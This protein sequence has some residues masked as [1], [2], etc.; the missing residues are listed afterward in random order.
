MKNKLTFA[1]LFAGLFLSKQVYSAGECLGYAGSIVDFISF[2]AGSSCPIITSKTV[3]GVE[4]ELIRHSGPLNNDPSGPT[5][6]ICSVFSDG[7][8]TLGGPWKYTGNPFGGETGNPD[9]LPPLTPVRPIDWQEPTLNN[10][11]EAVNSNLVKLSES[12]KTLS[13]S[14][15]NTITDSAANQ[16][17]IAARVDKVNT[18]VQAAMSFNTNQTAQ[19]IQTLQSSLNSAQASIKDNDDDNFQTLYDQAERHN[20]TAVQGVNDIRQQANQ[21]Q[22]LSWQVD[23][24]MGTVLTMNNVMQEQMQQVFDGQQNSLNAQ[25]QYYSMLQAPIISMQQTLENLPTGGSGGLSPEDSENLEAVAE[26]VEDTVDAVEDVED[27]ISGMRSSLSDDLYWTTG[28]LGEK[29][30]AINSTLSNGSGGGSD[31]DTETNQ[32]LDGIGQGIQEISDALKAGSGQNTGPTLCT[33]DDCYKGKSWVTP[34][35]P[36]GITS[37]YEDHK[38]KFQDSTIHEYMKGFVPQLSGA[39][40]NSWEF[41]IN[42]DGMAN[43]G[44]HTVE[45]P[46]YVI[47]FVRLIILISAGFLCRRLIF[48]G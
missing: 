44:C 41:C 19:Q 47:S 3:S 14:L 24:V 38:A 40:P 26:G 27:A 28:Q 43:L 21:I 15:N 30:D 11:G 25:D 8:Q 13:A 37:I 20:A 23:G 17:N 36:E 35:Y 33:G 46:P 31:D 1:L 2:P 39:A 22:S 42:F 16:R 18:D 5:D 7:S 6:F 45:L 10:N 12:F 34:K 48:G 29:L 32:K 9:P 4:C